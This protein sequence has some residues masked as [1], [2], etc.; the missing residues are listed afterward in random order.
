MPS[1]G[2]HDVGLH[3]LVRVF[4][5]AVQAHQRQV[6]LVLRPPQV[7][8]VTAAARAG[9]SDGSRRRST[10]VPTSSSTR[11]YSGNIL[12][13]SSGGTRL[14]GAPS[15][16]MSVRHDS[17]LTSLS[18][19]TEDDLRRYVV[20]GDLHHRR[21]HARA[22]LE[23]EAHVGERIHHTAGVLP[24][25]Q[26]RVVV[27]LVHRDQP[28]HRQVRPPR[29][30]ASCRRTHRRTVRSSRR[31]RRARR[32]CPTSPRDTPGDSTRCRP[33][34]PTSM[35]SFIVSSVHSSCTG[36]MGLPGAPRSIAILP[37]SGRNSLNFS[38][39]ACA[40]GA[41]VAAAV[42]QVVDARFADLAGRPRHHLGPSSVAAR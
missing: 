7:G 21:R 39:Q 31:C 22:T 19:H 8:L 14:D 30:P 34:R 15:G 24:G 20:A 17:S 2:R 4:T 38:P 32:G 11:C 40:E 26:E 12:D 16:G 13:C 25:A 36:S 3:V 28:V 37:P 23:Q 33:W 6:H 9:H 10:P 41:Q 5:V 1:A 18:S 27:G 35:L 29:R 42:G